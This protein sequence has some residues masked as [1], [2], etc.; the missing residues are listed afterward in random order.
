MIQRSL[1]NLHPNPWKAIFCQHKVEFM[2]QVKKALY[3]ITVLSMLLL[4]ISAQAS[5]EVHQSIPLGINSIEKMKPN[6]EYSVYVF[7]DTEWQ[8]VGDLA[9]DKGKG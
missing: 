6:G 3:I 5:Y 9:F 4:H 1:V 2:N 7:Q 8:K